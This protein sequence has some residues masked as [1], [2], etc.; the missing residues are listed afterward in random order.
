MVGISPHLTLVQT[1]HQAQPHQLTRLGLLWTLSIE[2]GFSK[3]P[4]TTTLEYR[5][6]R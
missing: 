4:V 2:P 5:T 1:A 6:Y 3:M